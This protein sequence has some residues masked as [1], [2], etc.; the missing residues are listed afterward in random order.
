MLDSPDSRSRF[1][2]ECTFTVNRLNEVLCK[3]LRMEACF[4]VP[5][6]FTC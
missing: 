3:G 6:F 4:S 5:F 1:F 2:G